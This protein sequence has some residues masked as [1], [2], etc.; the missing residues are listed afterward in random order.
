MAYGFSG[1]IGYAKETG[2]GSGTVVTSGDYI[3]ALSEDLTLSIERFGYKA[4]IGSL[5]EPDDATGLF[6]VAGGIRLAA[7]PMWLLPF[8]KSNLQSVV[9]T[10]GTGPLYSHA[11]QTT[12]GGGDFSSAVP[13]Q[14]Y[15]FEIFRDIGTSMR[16]TGCL[17]DTLA[18][19]FSADGPVMCEAGVLGKDAEAIAKTT[20]TFVT[21]P[22]KPFNFD[23][24]SLSLGGAGTALIES[25]TVTINNNFEGLGA[26][27][28][29]NR[30]SKVRRSNHQMVEVRG[31]LDFTDNT[32]YQKFVDQTEQRIAINATR[33]A[34][35][36]MLIDI[37]RLV[38][39]AFP[40]GIPGRERITVD[41]TGKGFVHQ[42]SGLALKLTLTSVQSLK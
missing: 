40:V 14:P 2:W 17:I 19:T 22:A 39:T 32:E 7:N 9:T 15:S 24:V 21:S 33:A 1:H 28:L 29:S 31:T 26:L 37:P 35:F 41:F 6:R 25:L 38:Y 10:S 4:I 5:S 12:S 18:F 16:Y 11:F 13:N 34:S 8:L 30:I 3:E 36:A 42:G 20:P 27:A 23:T